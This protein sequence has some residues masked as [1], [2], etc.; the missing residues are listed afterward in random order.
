MVVSCRAAVQG[1]TLS[2]PTPIM[3]ASNTASD[4]KPARSAAPTALRLRWRWSEDTGLIIVFVLMI[5]AIGIPHPEFFSFGS[6][7][8]ILRQ[9]AL[10]GIIAFGMV[11]LVAMVEIDLSVGGIFAV[12]EQP[13]GVVD[14]IS[15]CRSLDRGRVR[16]GGGHRS[17]RTQRRSDRRSEGSAH[18]RFARHLV[19]LFRS[20]SHLVRRQGDLWSAERATRSFTWF[21]SDF[22]AASGL[23]LDRDRLRHRAVFCF[24]SYALW[25]DRSRH[26]IESGGRGIH[27]RAHQ[28]SF[29]STRLRWSA[30][31]R[32]FPA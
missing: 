10:V 11:Y 18:H 17:R 15:S 13:G 14:Q 5:L 8:T 22:L 26:R 21:G 24:C 20:A 9:S 2:E 28:V 32:R 7:K 30:S 12:A 29:A 4:A 6:I 23:G 1:I 25:R 19:G 31:W 27:R 3:T 16:A